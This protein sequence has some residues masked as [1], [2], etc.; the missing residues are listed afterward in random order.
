MH[1][2]VSADGLE[3]QLERAEARIAEL[4]AECDD[5]KSRV[6]KLRE[7]IEQCAHSME[8]ARIWDGMK[9]HWNSLHSIP[10]VDVWSRLRVALANSVE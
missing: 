8:V 4:T 6:V 10:V 9:W 3:E 7:A 2:H 1:R 5:L